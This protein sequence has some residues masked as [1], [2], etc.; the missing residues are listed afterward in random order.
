MLRRRIRKE[1]DEFGK[2]V[3]ANREAGNIGMGQVAKDL[4]S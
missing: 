3:G 2:H 4:V 1:D